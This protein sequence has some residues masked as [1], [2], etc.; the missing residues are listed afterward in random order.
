M[1]TDTVRSALQQSFV[2]HIDAGFA[3]LFVQSVEQHEALREMHEVAKQNDWNFATFDMDRGLTERERPNGDLDR[4]E[5][6]RWLKKQHVRHDGAAVLVLINGHKMLDDLQVIQVLTHAV[7]D[8]KENRRFVV[9]LGT[10]LTLPP[11]LEKLFVVLEHSLPNREAL[12][13]I[14]RHV[15][16]EEDV[17]E[18]EALNRLLDAA[19]GLTH[20]EAEGAFALSVVRNNALNVETLWEIKAGM[21]KKTGTLELYRGNENF[22]DL[23]GLDGLK[24]FCRGVLTSNSGLLSK[25]VMLVGVPGAGKSAFA[26]ALGTETGRPTVTLDFGA[27]KGS[28]VGQSEERTRAA[29]K[30]IDAMA[31]CVLFIDEIEKGLSGGNSSHDGDN[32]VSAGILG[33]FLTWLND[34]TS[35]VFV[36]CTANN[37]AKLPPEFSRAERFDGVFFFD[38]PN[39]EQRDVIWNL[40]CEKFGI[41][42]LIGEGV[43][44]W[45][46]IDDDEWTGAEIKACCRLAKLQGVTLEQASINIV[47]VAKRGKGVISSLREWAEN[48]VLDANKGG[49]YTRPETQSTSNGQS[50]GRRVVRSK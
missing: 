43:D 24:T 50:S 12:D 15:A 1:S 6:I 13:D 16:T 30:A 21:L 41:P 32:G 47:P 10:S 3:G 46:D 14:M 8:G 31:P 33:S 17:P 7:I 20:Y 44:A 5:A 39:A 25:G 22:D 27:L 37:I 9:I 35:D 18:G 42:A 29:L 36:I 28:M 49:I 19:S 26:K 11:E 38:M 45:D 4:V 48:N 34:H 23:G 2:E 40:Y